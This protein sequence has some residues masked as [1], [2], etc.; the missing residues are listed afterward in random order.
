M[1]EQP[2]RLSAGASGGAIDRERRLTFTFDGRSYTGHPGDTLASALLANGVRLV[3]RS[4]KY[5][6][7]RGIVS[8]GAEE[9]NALVG[10][11]AGARYEPNTRATMTPLTDGLVAQSQNRWPSL[12]FD[13][14]ALTGVLS[15]LFPAGF[16]YKTFMGGGQKAWHLY[17]RIIRN[18]AGL[19]VS[20][21]QADADRYERMH[22]HCDV[23]VVGGG[24]TG[25]A[26]AKAAAE[27]GA[28]VILADENEGFGGWLRR[29]RLSVD[30]ESGA[31]WAA[32]VA[33][34]LAGAPNVTLLPRTTAFGHYDHN[35]VA[36][37]ERVQDHLPEPDPDLPRQRL[38]SVRARRVVHAT[39]A[40]ERPLVF[41]GNDR[42]GVMLAASARAYVNQY[43]VAPGWTAVI[44]TNNDSGYRTALDLHAAGL[45]VAAVVDVRPKGGGALM[46][47]VKEKGLEVLTGH[48]VVTT[49][50]GHGV[51][52]AEVMALSEDGARVEGARRRIP[53]DLVA[54]SGGWSPAVHL[55]SQAGGRPVYD[56]RIGAFVPGA[57]KQAERSAG[58]AAGTLNLADCLREGFKTGAE[59]AH[60]TGHGSGTAPERPACDSEDR[61]HVRALW[62]IPGSRSMG[63]NFID[64]QNDVTAKD[65]KLAHREGYGAVEH[66]KRYT[67]LGMATDQGKTSNVNGHALLAELR[68][69][70][71]D[72]VG[73]TTFRPPYTPVTF[74]TLA[75]QDTGAHLEPTRRTP[76]HDWHVEHGAVFTSAGL[77]L[78]AQYYPK[79]GESAH[80]AIQREAR[81][82]RRAVGMV[83]VSTLGKI[84]I[85][86]PD[87]AELLN[88]VYIN[89]WKRLPVGKARYGAML[90]EDG[91]VDDDGTTSRLGE[92][93]Y[94]MTTTTGKAGSVMA[95][96]ERHLAVDWP[97]L[98]VDVASV[99]EQWATMA[100][101]GPKSREVLARV[102][103]DADVS[104]EALPFMG[105]TTA[106]VAGVPGRIFR[107]SFSGELAYE[108]AVPADYGRAVWERVMAAGADLGI[109]PYGTEALGVL[110]TEKGH[111]VA[112][113]LDGRTSPGDLGLGRMLSGKKDYIGR[114]ALEREAFHDEGRKVQVGLVPVDASH[115]L[116]PGSQLTAEE[117]PEI[118]ATLL[119]HI[120]STSFSPELGHSIALAFL[121][122]GRER[123]GEVVYAQYPLYGETV[124]ARVTSPVF[125]DPEGAR[126]HA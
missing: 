107:I 96:L 26:A 114:R 64:F 60:A 109:A 76:M 29:E 4:F 24:P 63:R 71:M 72:Q 86:G 50:G 121:E 123:E 91:M 113:E 112:A 23:L 93:H 35:N 88:R 84:D 101:A 45:G 19:G 67:T 118:P 83:D 119:G 85:Q 31:A 52:A 90:R 37:A 104:N 32:G 61:G 74:G 16:Y 116:R 44:A 115:K 18:A 80:E 55:H 14:N 8:A 108:I 100:L 78:R 41:A 77:W 122:R 68:G 6:R 58:A 105:V 99:T 3:G 125:V 98:R 38:W 66:L 120:S 111:P 102:V 117:Q 70:P 2:H 89:G 43:A 97:E 54:M 126:L 95:R 20:P 34:E 53:C 33:G 11:G 106:T 21:E 62:A 75:G 49:R 69:E 22:A 46:R 87:A 15:P 110:R 30:G 65:V 10:L 81:T 9:P 103:E 82:V 1:S 56:D 124:A 12:G 73:T 17:E 94:V 47:Q 48:T 5:H 36:L 57:S 92:T 59:A 42:P 40:I 39:G 7:P 28:R 79:P 27:T 13:V 51:R 25:L